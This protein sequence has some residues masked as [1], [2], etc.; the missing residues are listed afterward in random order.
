MQYHKDPKFKDSLALANSVDPN[1]TPPRGAVC[2][3]NLH[4]LPFRLH[5]LDSLLY[6]RATLFKFRILTVILHVSEYLGFVRYL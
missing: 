1:Q 6:G 3:Q 5:L 2:D 4:C